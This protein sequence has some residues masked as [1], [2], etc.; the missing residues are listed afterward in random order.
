M[1]DLRQ[2]WRSI[3][4]PQHVEK[5]SGRERIKRGVW[6]GASTFGA[7]FLLGVVYIGIENMGYPGEIGWFL[8]AW[9]ALDLSIWQWGYEKFDLVPPWQF[10]DQEVDDAE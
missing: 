10:R 6:M 9:F 8:L 2:W 4:E 7:V 3:H 5:A 1:P